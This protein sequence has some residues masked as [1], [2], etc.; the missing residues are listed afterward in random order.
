MKMDTT[1]HAFQH[2]DEIDDPLTSVLRDG[3]RRLLA[4]IQVRYSRLG[5]WSS[6]FAHLRRE[7]SP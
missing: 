7:A 5:A 2:P 4:K 1:V 3:A 6:M